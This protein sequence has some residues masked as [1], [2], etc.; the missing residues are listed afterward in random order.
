MQMCLNL[1][2]CFSFVSSES[3]IMNSEWVMPFNTKVKLQGLVKW[4]KKDHFG[5]VW[6]G[7][8]SLFNSISTFVGYLM[9]KP[10]LLKNSSG[11]I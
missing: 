6:F 3:I 5:L 1:Y 4:K 2:I 11:I 10:S 9:S 7:L 8:V